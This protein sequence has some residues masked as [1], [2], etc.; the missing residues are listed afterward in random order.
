VSRNH[1]EHKHTVLADEQSALATRK[2]YPHYLEG[3]EE[4]PKARAYRE[5]YWDGYHNALF[6]FCACGHSMHGAY[7]EAEAAHADITA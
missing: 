1:G 7:K 4:T 2:M 5:A 6:Q 3:G